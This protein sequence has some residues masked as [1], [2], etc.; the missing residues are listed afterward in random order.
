M[1]RAD[2][3][4]VKT[5]RLFQKRLHLCAVL[6]DDVGVIP[7]R[8]VHIIAHE[9]HLVGKQS[10]VQGAESA[11]SV[12]GKQNLIRRVVAHHDLRPMHHRRHDE[13]ETVPSRGERVSLCDKL[14]AGID[15]E[16]EKLLYHRRNF[17]VAE[18]FHIRIPH[19]KLPQRRGVIRLHM[20]N[21]E[22]IERASGEKLLDILEK[23]L[24]HRMID[25]VEQHGLFIEQKI[26]IVGNAVRNGI[27]AL[28]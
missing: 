27:D 19:H 22:I 3:F 17:C 21:H 14:R 26:R 16:I 10:A 28:E 25:C 12:R 4:D 11:E 13:R 9:V 5:G 7:S 24:F 6:A 1:Q 23:H 18:D 20:V 2:H 15:V 8:L